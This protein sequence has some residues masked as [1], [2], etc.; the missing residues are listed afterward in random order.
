MQQRSTPCRR[1]RRR[2]WLWLLNWLE[3]ALYAVIYF[4]LATA[5]VVESKCKAA[6]KRITLTIM[7]TVIVNADG[8]G[9]GDPMDFVPTGPVPLHIALSCPHLVDHSPQRLA[10]IAVFI[11]RL[12]AAGVTNVSVYDPAHPI[13]QQ[14]VLDAIRD[15]RRRRVRY[16]EQHE[17]YH[18]HH[19]RVFEKADSDSDSDSDSDD[20]DIDV[21]DSSSM[22]KEHCDPLRRHGTKVCVTHITPEETDRQFVFLPFSVPHSD[23]VT[24]KIHQHDDD[25]HSKPSSKD[26]SEQRESKCP[27]STSPISSSTSSCPL[28]TAIQL[29]QQEG[30]QNVSNCNSSVN[31]P[32]AKYSSSP[33]NLTLLNPDSGY[34]ALVRAARKLATCDP[35]TISTSSTSS[36]NSSSSSSPLPP[37][38]NLNQQSVSKHQPP[39]Q[40]QQQRAKFC[41]DDVCQWLDTNPVNANLPS[42]PDVLLV[43][44]MPNAPPVPILHGFPVWQLRLTQLIFSPLGPDELSM[45]QLFRMISTAACAPKRFGT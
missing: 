33:V 14:A 21:D 3:H 41:I 32:Y 11:T 2:P 17:Q 19:H 9:S 37:P 18:H 25:R 28:S 27:T 5:E 6:M 7:S 34:S 16:Q 42:E 30:K 39:P 35:S 40:Q 23:V 45:R 29:H 15:C 1:R 38:A 4:V 24:D 20:V 44:P 22:R 8:S 31:V 26:I 36:V 10:A 13:S 12:Y 43:F